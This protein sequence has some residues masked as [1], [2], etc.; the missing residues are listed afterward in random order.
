MT[1]YEFHNLQQFFDFLDG[2]QD[3][4]REDHFM[5]E[6]YNAVNMALSCSCRQRKKNERLQV[7]KSKYDS[8]PK[9]ISDDLKIELKKRL[10][11]EKIY[12]LKD[13]KVFLE[14]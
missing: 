11:V 1:D 12:F 7:A 6:F 9:T 10:G 14:L 8:L 13:N 4:L 3:I 2:H 5:R